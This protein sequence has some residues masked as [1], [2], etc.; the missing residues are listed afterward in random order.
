MSNERNDYEEHNEMSAIA[1]F[2]DTASPGARQVIMMPVKPENEELFLKKCYA[3][4]RTHG[5]IPPPP[6]HVQRRPML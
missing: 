4:L 5:S 6:S 1:N 3:G 2:N